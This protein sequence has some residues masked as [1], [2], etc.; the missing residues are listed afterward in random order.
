MCDRVNILQ[1][2]RITFDRPTT[3]TSVAELTELMVADYRGRRG[4]RR[5]APTEE[6]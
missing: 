4:A 1:H 2:G 5:P 3:E 6:A